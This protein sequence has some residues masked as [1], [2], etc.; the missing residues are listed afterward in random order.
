M[1]RQMDSDIMLI[2]REE[3]VIKYPLPS[4]DIGKRIGLLEFRFILYDLV[5]KLESINNAQKLE[6]ELPLQHVAKPEYFMSDLSKFL[7]TILNNM[8]KVSKCNF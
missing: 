3:L 5:C 6:I 2:L 4:D 7:Q 1:V 8:K